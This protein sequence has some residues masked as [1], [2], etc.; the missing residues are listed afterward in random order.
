MN[1]PYDQ[2][3]TYPKH[4][5]DWGHTSHAEPEFQIYCIVLAAEGW[6]EYN[7]ATREYA[8]CFAKQYD[9]PTRCHSNHDKEGVQVM[10]SV[11]AFDGRVSLELELCAALKDETWVKILNYGLPKNVKEATAL[12]PR[13]LAAWEAAN[14]V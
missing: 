13:M 5:K 14:K 6:H 2:Q 3:K 10:I 9:T 1:T 12:I 8:R 11:S 7:D 4:L